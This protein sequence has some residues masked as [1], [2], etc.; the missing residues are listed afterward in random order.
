MEDP[1][2]E[3]PLQLARACSAYVQG[4]SFP[5]VEPLSNDCNGTDEP[6]SVSI[7]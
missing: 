2:L 1:Q 7:R 4:K 5:L 6:E 3:R